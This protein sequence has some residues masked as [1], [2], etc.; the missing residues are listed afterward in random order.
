MYPTLHLVTKH[1]K[2]QIL[3]ALFEEHGIHL[4]G[5]ARLDTDE[6]G[7]FTGTIK[8]MDDAL[9]TARKK[10]ERAHQLF[11][12]PWIM[13]SEGSFVP[14]PMVPFATVNIEVLWSEDF[15]RQQGFWISHSTLET[16]AQRRTFDSEVAF[17]DWLESIDFPQ[18]G[19]W[20]IQAGS[21][22]HPVATWQEL[23]VFLHD[24]WK[25]GDTWEAETD[26]RA[27]RNPLRRKA[28]FEAGKKWLE[29]YQSTC[30]SCA[31]RGFYP[32]KTDGYKRCLAC[33]TP[34][35]TPANKVWTCYHCSCE[36]S[37]PIDPHH[38]YEDP[39]YCSHCNP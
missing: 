22:F 13:S 38:R 33:G 5:E 26:Q 16:C 29:A 36:Q 28:I 15:V 21:I 4:L 2:E 1:E 35:Q 23:E 24:V 20:M 37:E 39:M 12:H 19:V 30:P 11:R 27:H 6:F 32:R 17:I 3:R 31:A 7:T 25:Q 9:I 34:T 14:H 10:A 18:Q 8:R